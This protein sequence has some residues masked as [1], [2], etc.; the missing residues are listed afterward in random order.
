MPV[1]P[2]IVISISTL[3]KKRSHSLISLADPVKSS[4]SIKTAMETMFL[5]LINPHI[6]KLQKWQSIIQL[7][8]W[9]KSLILILLYVIEIKNDLYKIC[10]TT[11]L[12]FLVFWDQTSKS[13]NLQMISILLISEFILSLNVSEIKNTKTTTF[14]LVRI[15]LL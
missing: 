5:M 9:S 1:F 12:Q 11:K 15:F 13:H 3:V 8:S 4:N 2:I 14:E 10:T 7:R 6:Q